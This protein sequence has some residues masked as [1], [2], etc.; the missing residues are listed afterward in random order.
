ML[1]VRGLCKSIGGR[2]ILAG[3]SFDLGGGELLV[4]TGPNGSGKTT[5]LRLLAG[6]SRPN[7]G[8]I[9]L[10]GLPVQRSR[11]HL[12]AALGYLA[13]DP[14]LYPDLTARENLAFWARVYGLP[15]PAARIE[16]ALERWGLAAAADRPVRSFSRGM[17]QR[18][19]LARTLL[20]EPRI[21]L[22]DEPATGLD[23]AARQRLHQALAEHLAAG[24]AAVVASHDELP[25]PPGRRLRLEAGRLVPA[26]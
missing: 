9:E 16:A 11:P 15:Q 22:L 12:R 25:G 19:N 18:L 14:F 4:V 20:A 7:A 10:D 21:L 24:G 17:R 2:T 23:E 6:V 8:T 1:R 13:H 26:S 5:L 3:V